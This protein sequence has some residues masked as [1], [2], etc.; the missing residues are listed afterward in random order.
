MKTILKAL[1]LLIALST[2]VPV[3]AQSDF[4]AIKA[5][6]EAGDADFQAAL[7][8]AYSNGK[9]VPK[10]DHEA[11]RWFTLASEQGHA[12]A[13]ALLGS[14][15]ARGRGVMQD[16]AQAVYWYRL[17]AQQG[18]AS[19]QY[20]VG[21]RYGTGIGTTLDLTAAYVWFSV[22]AA[23]GDA[24]ASEARDNVRNRLSPQ[25]LEEAQAQATRCFESN[26]QDC[27]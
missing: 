10:N 9:L 11:V 16:D 13:Q 7:G 18:L 26:Y 21:V 4:E 24:D 19:A 1:F 27:D 3:F 8:A 20:F 2:A 12:S 17:A 15:Y 25:A 22:A 5:R 6:A 14:M 23:Q